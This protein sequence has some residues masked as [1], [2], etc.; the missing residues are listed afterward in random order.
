VAIDYYVSMRFLPLLLVLGALHAQTP[1]RKADQA[2]PATDGSTRGDWPHYRGTQLS[3]RYS[4]LDQITAA[5]VKN[6][7]S[8]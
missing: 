1:Q 3:W 5:N 4:A 6:L 2:T 8:A 7:T